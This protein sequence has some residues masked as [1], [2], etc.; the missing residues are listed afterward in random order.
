[1]ISRL[2]LSLITAFPHDF[3]ILDEIHNHA[4]EGFRQKIST[5]M[6]KTIETSATFIIVS[7]NLD[8]LI[9]SCERGIVFDAGRVLFDGNI[10]KAIAC[11]RLLPIAE[12]V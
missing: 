7:H 9:L 8:D 6:K 4:D 1:M 10:E 2:A 11:Y 3:L 12:H 5:R